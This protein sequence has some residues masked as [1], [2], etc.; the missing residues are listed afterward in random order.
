MKRL[1]F[2]ACLLSILSAPS[3]ALGSIDVS[4]RVVQLAKAAMI[5]SATLAV[6]GGIS[7]A[8]VGSVDWSTATRMQNETDQFLM[9]QA[10]GF[11]IAALVAQTGATFCSVGGLVLALRQL[12]DAGRVAVGLLYVSLLLPIVASVTNGMSARATLLVSGWDEDVKDRVSAL[13]TTSIVQT[14]VA[15][16]QTLIYLGY[17]GYLAFRVARLM[18]SERLLATAPSDTSANSVGL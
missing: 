2:V 9:N 1:L 10:G 17:V 13:T 8:I 16:T 18:K 11:Q 12:K 6:A 7:N 15:G 3:Q 4:P 14:V 5:T